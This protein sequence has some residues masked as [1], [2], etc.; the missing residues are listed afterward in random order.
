MGAVRA[1]LDAAK[2]AEGRIPASSASRALGLSNA[3]QVGVKSDGGPQ[4]NRPGAAAGDPLLY[5]RG[6]SMYGAVRPILNP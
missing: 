5:G 3:S 6:R 1:A 4:Q 2:G